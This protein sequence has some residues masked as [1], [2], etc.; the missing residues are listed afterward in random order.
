M[1]TYNALRNIGLLILPIAALAVFQFSAH[2]Q[3]AY[4]SVNFSSGEV[5]AK[6]VE[7]YALNSC[8]LEDR[9]DDTHHLYM[10]SGDTF[11]FTVKFSET[12][13]KVVV[14]LKHL[15][16]ADAKTKEAG[17][18]PVSLYVNGERAKSWESFSAGYEVGEITIRSIKE[19]ENMFELRYANEGG[20]TGYWVKYIQ[21]YVY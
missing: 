6:G 1:N 11:S 10:F 5:V 2:A 15:S 18:T 4:A 14:K 20:T 9:F 3:T 8:K 19:G 16:S 17:K 12:P 7:S 13:K 21:V